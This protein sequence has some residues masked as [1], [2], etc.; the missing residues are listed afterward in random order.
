MIFDADTRIDP[1]TVVVET[2]DTSITNS[3]MLASWGP[4]NLAV[5]TE[6]TWMYVF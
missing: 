6:L 5:R 3:T 4:Q 1:R 2:F